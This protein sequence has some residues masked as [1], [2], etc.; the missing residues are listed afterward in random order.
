MSC[1]P[2][3]FCFNNDYVLPATVAVFS[4]LKN[5]DKTYF[6]HLYVLQADITN[7]NKN[8]LIKIVELFDNAAIE[9]INVRNKF[10]NLFKKTKTKEH[11]SKEIY[12]KF[13][14]PNLFKQYDKIIITDVDVVFQ[15]DIS[16]TFNAFDVN[17]DY[18]LSGVNALIKSSIFDRYKN[19]FSEDEINQLKSTGAGYWIFNLKKMRKDDMEAKFIE[20]ATKNSY[21][22][23][24]PEQDTV[25]ILCYPKIKYLPPNIMIG[26]ELYS[27]CDTDDYENNI[28]IS[29]KEFLYAL[30]NPVQLRYPGPEKPWLN[31][32]V[33]KSEVWFDYLFQTPFY[34]DYFKEIISKSELI[35]KRKVLFKIK[36]PLSSK[37]LIIAKEKC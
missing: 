4:L 29:K 20:Y 5:A 16:K 19:E 14:A 15:G 35:K 7:Y 13:L 1:I 10:S 28:R 36:L 25:N 9:F 18:Y 33:P 34:K 6:Y 32:D 22:L 2:V 23:K 30:E 3:M 11:Y 24:Q 26:N 8:K 37:Y 12:Y 21:R 17:E 31:P 27:L